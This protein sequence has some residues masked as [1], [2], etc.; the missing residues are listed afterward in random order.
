MHPCWGC[1][2]T[3]DGRDLS[4][5]VAYV[6]VM[7]M[8]KMAAVV[9]VTGLMGHAEAQTKGSGSGKFSFTPPPT[10]GE[11]AVYERT[12]LRPLD[13]D[14]APG[15]PPRA[16]APSYGDDG[17]PD[18]GDSSRTR[19]S[20]DTV[21]SLTS[22]DVRAARQEQAPDL[23]WG[24]AV[25]VAEPSAVQPQEAPGKKMQKTQKAPKAAAKPKR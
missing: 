23:E 17:Q 1:P 2:S 20:G 13:L 10:K 16:I 18:W 3:E 21:R 15:R 7:R 9:L 6:G 24:K 22:A 14:A 8:T 12:Q 5:S 11:G 4:R 25:A 19:R